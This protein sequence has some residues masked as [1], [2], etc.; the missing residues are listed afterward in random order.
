MAADLAGGDIWL[1]HVE[2][3]LLPFWSGRAALGHPIGN[4]PTFRCNDGSAYVPD[5]PCAELQSPPAWIRQEI[6]RD[7]V[8]MQARQTYAYGV[9]FNL[10]GDT[11]WLDLARAGARRTLA[12]LDSEGGAP[13]WFEQGRGM[14]EPSARTAQ[15][16]SY[17]VVGIAM[18]Y[19][20]TRDP[21]L[22]KALITHQ[23]FVFARYWDEDWKMLRWVP[24]DGPA[25]ETAKQELVAQLDQLNAYMLLV[26]PYLPPAARAAWHADI[27]RVADTLV[28]QFHDPAS[29]TFFGT[30]E[31]GP[32][33]RRAGA[34]HNDFGHTIKAYWMLMLAG[35]ELGDVELERFGRDGGAAILDRAWDEK[36]GAWAS[37]WRESG[38]DLSK[39]WWIFAELDQMNSF[40]AMEQPQRAE[41]LKSSWRF[42]LEKMT[43]PGGGEIYGWVDAE[44]NPPPNSLRI[45]Q[46]KSGYHSFEHALISYLTAQSLA[47][48]RAVLH[49]ALPQSAGEFRPYLLPGKAVSVRNT[50][51]RQRVEFEIPVKK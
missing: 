9:A 28:R 41:R 22:E 4:F 36:S 5:A 18:L 46:W 11:R 24:K 44:G 39:S 15:D 51:G 6:G 17:A 23:H 1:R 30:L 40:L 37:G 31:R 3:D 33:S 14:P 38:L 42:W 12:L 49:F 19:Y 35:R 25:T 29:G 43:A 27:R 7:F 34:R 2:R 13:T 32:E 16:Q 48:K 10:T 50:C 45:H 47:G 26:V 20:L 8:R 21:A